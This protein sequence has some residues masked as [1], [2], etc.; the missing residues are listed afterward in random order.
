MQNV[1][2]PLD[3]LPLWGLFVATMAAVLLSVEAGYRFGKYRL[4]LGAGEKEGPVG[5][6]VA[7]TLALLAFLLTFTFGMAANRFEARRQAVLEESNAIGTTWLRAGL[8]AEPHRTEVRK[9]LR[10]YVEVRIAA[11]ENNR[12]EPAI[13]RSEAIHAELWSHAAAAADSDSKSIIVG[14]FIQSLNETIDL[15]TV[16]INAGLRSRIPMVIWGG[17]FAVT[18]LAM[19]VTGY[20]EGLASAARTPA[21]LALVLAFSGVI[22]LIAD[23]DR[24][25][26]GLLRVSQQLLMDVQRGM[27]TP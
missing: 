8:L 3:I 12:V 2:T 22:V 6:M 26:E 13:A 23:L 9:L 14:L 27:N 24:P 25:H 20:Q 10:E 4:R 21:I 5:A 19:L 7:A 15:H 18:A 17:L 1:T 16:R 11:V